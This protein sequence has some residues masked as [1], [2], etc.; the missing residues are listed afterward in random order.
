MKNS[1]GRTLWN[2]HGLPSR[3]RCTIRNGD[4]LMQ[5]GL[6]EQTLRERLR[7]RSTPELSVLKTS[8]DV[9]R[10]TEEDAEG[11]LME[12]LS[13]DRCQETRKEAV[14]D[15][16]RLILDPAS[17][18]KK[19]SIKLT[20]TR[21][22]GN[23]WT[24]A[25]TQGSADLYSIAKKQFGPKE[26]RARNE[27][28]RPII[29]HSRI[30]NQIQ[31]LQQLKQ[32]YRERGNSTHPAEISRITRKE[33]RESTKE[34]LAFTT[35]PNKFARNLLDKER[36]GYLLWKSCYRTAPAAPTKDE[37][38]ASEP[39]LGDLKDFI[40]QAD[41]VLLLNGRPSLTKF[42]RCFFVYFTGYGDS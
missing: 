7:R 24:K 29:T 11:P 39:T 28:P 20:P 15:R 9:L 41:L 21:N 2:R 22:Y 34:R 36:S 33:A 31:K 27:P 12:L 10:E 16:S 3:Q 37:L 42:T 14:L 8:H 35:N 32:R 5:K 30:D 17:R 26:A 19:T 1:L 25:S 13:L 38:I 23:C 18:H 4:L 6:Q 40:K